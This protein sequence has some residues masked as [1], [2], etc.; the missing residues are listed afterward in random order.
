MGFCDGSQEEVLPQIQKKG[1]ILQTLSHSSSVTG[2]G[3]FARGRACRRQ[4]KGQKG[5][6]EKETSGK[7][8]SKKSRERSEEE[9]QARESREEER[10]SHEEKREE[11][12]EAEGVRLRCGGG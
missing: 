7:E 11:E 4:G 2:S 10:E 9:A 8:S 3:S 5:R 1:H 12:K 6:E